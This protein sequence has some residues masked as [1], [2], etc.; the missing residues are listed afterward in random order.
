MKIGI[1]GLGLIGGSLG[2]DLTRQGYNVI[3]IS[4]QL[5]TCNLAIKKRIVTDATVDFSILAETELIFICTPIEAILS[6]I[7]SII[8]YLPRKT[9]ITDVGSVKGAIV[10]KATELWGNFVGS[11]PMAGTI[12]Q[13]IEAAEFDLFKNAPCVI[14]PV[15]NT[16]TDAIHKVTQIWRSLGC[17]MYESTPEIHDQAVAWISHLPVMISANL[18]NSCLNNDNQEVIEL[19]QNLASSGFK[20]TSRVGGGNV[21]LGLMMAQY[22][23]K[24]LLVTLKEYQENLSKIIEN[25]EQKKWNKLTEI[26]TKTQQERAK[27]L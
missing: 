22:N 23:R 17:K 9:I 3:G 6:T 5:T 13:G 24:Q 14:T 27:F 10:Y 18:I 19:A 15:K 4:R 21:E 7:K 11:H 2:L 16:S 8:Q 26:L 12:N 20:D 25:I 1:I